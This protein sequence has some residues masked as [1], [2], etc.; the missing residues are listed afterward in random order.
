MKERHLSPAVIELGV[1]ER[2]ASM[3]TQRERRPATP[4]IRAPATWSFKRFCEKGFW[5]CRGC[6]RPTELAP[7]QPI[8]VGCGSPR[9]EWQR[10][11]F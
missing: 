10:P 2:P 4:P 3:P 11:I 9:V 6:G 7:D 8:C 1:H 5:L